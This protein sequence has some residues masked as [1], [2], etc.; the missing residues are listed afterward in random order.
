MELV[1]DNIKKTFSSLPPSGHNTAKQSFTNFLMVNI[2]VFSRIF[3]AKR[4]LIFK[5]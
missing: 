2:F 4:H 3:D 5:Q 1:L